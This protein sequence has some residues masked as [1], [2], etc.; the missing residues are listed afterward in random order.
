MLSQFSHKLKN[1]KDL[2]ACLHLFHTV[3]QTRLGSLNRAMVQK[4]VE[5]LISN[6]HVK[7]FRSEILNLL[8]IFIERFPKFV[9]PTIFYSDLLLLELLRFV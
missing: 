6:I 2:P 3:V 1:G 7:I 8:L 5:Y 9:A 4:L